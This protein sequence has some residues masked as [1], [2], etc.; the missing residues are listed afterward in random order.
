MVAGDRFLAARAA[1]VLVM[2]VVATLTTPR[3][4]HWFWVGPGTEWGRAHVRWAIVGSAAVVLLL[5]LSSD[6]ARR[7]IRQ[8]MNRRAGSTR[9][10]E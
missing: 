4:I 5:G 1:G 7:A 9:L 6:P 10:T 8:P 2:C 3:L